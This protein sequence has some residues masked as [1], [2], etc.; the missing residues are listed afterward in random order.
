MT[1]HVA[2]PRP[3]Y[4]VQAL[5]PALIDARALALLDNAALRRQLGKLEKVELASVWRLTEQALAR[6]PA[7]LPPL[8]PIALHQRLLDGLAGETLLVASAM[9][10]GSLAE[11]EQFFG[12]SFKTIKAR[13]GGSL[14]TAASERV[15]RVAR[16]FLGAADMLGSF[17]AARAYMHA[18]NFALGGATPAE[19]IRTGDGERIALDELQAQA[20]GAPL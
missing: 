2:E 12:M 7:T 9:F 1:W 14:D 15:L 10:L 17:E 5:G 13:L 11:A 16:V 8:D 20:E 4:Q 18:R 3:V 6:Q 19:L